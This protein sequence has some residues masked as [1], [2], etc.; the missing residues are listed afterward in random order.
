MGEVLADALALAVRVEP[1]RVHTG[2]A[3]HVL[4]FAVRPL[5]GGENGVGRLVVL[6]DPPAY[7]AAIRLLAGT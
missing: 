6:R 1:R 3:R 4:E 5:R 7:R 2:G